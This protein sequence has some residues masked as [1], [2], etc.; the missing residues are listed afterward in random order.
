M[1]ELG[2][3]RWEQVWGGETGSY[4]LGDLHAR[5][6]LDI[7]SRD[8]QGHQAVIS[9]LENDMNFGHQVRAKPEVREDPDYTPKVRT[10][11]QLGL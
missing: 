1:P 7:P 9:D 3:T 2:R 8:V 5:C 11:K 10:K 4:A 6:R